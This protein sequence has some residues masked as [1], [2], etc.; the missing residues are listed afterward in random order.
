M[1]EQKSWRVVNEGNLAR[2]WERRL[3]PRPHRQPQRRPARWVGWAAWIGMVWLGA[4]VA[5]VLATA[6]MTQG[7]RVDQLD[8]QYTNLIRQNQSLKATVATMVSAD[9]INQR[10]A[11]WHLQWTEPKPVPMSVGEKKP[12]PHSPALPF[13]TRWIWGLGQAVRSL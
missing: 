11:Q 5:A 1:V 4:V 6:V 2:T 10:A 12:V 3:K 13:M 7:Y 8:Q 9:Q